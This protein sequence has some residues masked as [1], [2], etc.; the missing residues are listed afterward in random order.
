MTASMKMVEQLAR[1]GLQEL[2]RT[3]WRDVQT[4]V[5]K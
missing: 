4:A 5:V 2:S 3:R 1:L